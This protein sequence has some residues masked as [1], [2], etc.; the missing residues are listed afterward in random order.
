MSGPCYY[1]VRRLSP[2]QGTVQVL[3][4][5][6]FR[7]ISADG[8]SWEIQ[9]NNRGSRFSTYGTWSR[10][11]RRQQIETEHTAPF[12]DA[13]KNH[14]ALPFPPADRLELWLL[15]GEDLLP[16]ALVSSTLPGITP[17]KMQEVNWRP[18]L[19]DDHSFIAPSLLGH[20]R[21]RQA[22]TAIFPHAE[23]LR[24]CV[25][26]AAGPVFRA[27]WFLRNANGDGHGKTGCRLDPSVI[28]RHLGRDAFPELII[29]ES[30]WPAQRERELVRDYHHWQ[31]ANLLTHPDLSRETRSRLE[32]AAHD[33]AERLYR[34]R[35]VLPDI[36]NEELVKTL[37]VEAVIRQSANQ[38]LGAAG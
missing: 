17:P 10:R 37:F 21:Y 9:I 3:E 13:L 38:S 18:A 8:L 5:P 28:D 11:G 26:M 29:S 15:D 27:Q 6:G 14:P 19:A 12:I 35:H 24:R 20:A 25:C 36:V 30:L 7:A 16:L 32:Q 23:V 1:S 4:S 33:Q 34:L 2:Y 22:P 31:A